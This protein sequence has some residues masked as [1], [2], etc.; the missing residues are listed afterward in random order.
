MGEARHLSGVT[1]THLAR[2]AATRAAGP[3]VVV[4]LAL[5]CAPRSRPTDAAWLTRDVASSG[6][7]V[8]SDSVRLHYLEAGRGRPIVFVPGWTMPAD[9]WEPQI[10]ALSAR[11]RVVALDPRSQGLSAHAPG[12][13]FHARRARDVR[14]LLEHLELRDVTL[15]GWSLGVP[16]LLAYVDQFGTD[17]LASLVMVDG[18]V[19]ATPVDVPQRMAAMLRMQREWRPYMAE[20]VPT[21]YATPQPEDYLRRVTD[22]AAR[23]PADAAMAL[24]ADL[25]F[26]PERDQRPALDRID[27][28]LLFVSARRRSGHAD[29]VA[30]HVRSARIEVFEDAGHALFVDRPERFNALLEAFAPPR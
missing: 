22:A 19:W 14:E 27:R 9:I 25:F 30:A 12:G 29:T 1:H 6:W 5:G 20:F 4:L 3:L 11:Y 10:R 15:V 24:Y 21:M 8:T 18:P 26:G 16:E 28:P 7:F 13:H 23:T 17:R 2:R